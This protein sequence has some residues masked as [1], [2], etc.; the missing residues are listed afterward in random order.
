MVV[1]QFYQRG[2]CKHGDRC[3]N[4]HPGSIRDR[5]RNFPGGNT[6]SNR[7]APLSGQG[8]DRYRSGGS[9]GFGGGRDSDRRNDDFG[10][11]LSVDTIKT[12]LTGDRPIYPL[13]AYGPGRDAPRQLIEGLVEI[14]PEELRLRYYVAKASGNEVAAQQEER[15]LAA[16]MNQQVDRILKDIAGAMR[17]VEEGIKV[18]GNRIEIASQYKTSGKF[19]KGRVGLNAPTGP[20]SSN[21][22]GGSSQTPA[23]GKPATSAFGQ[24]G[25]SPFG[26]PS[27]PGQTTSAFGQP[28]N[29]GHTTSAFSQ[30]S[31]VG[32]AGGF[33]KPSLPGSTSAFGQPSGLGQ[34]SAFG[35]P[36]GRGQGSAFGKPAM[37][38]AASAFGQTNAL[39]QGSAFGKSSVPGQTSAFGQTSTPGQTSGFGQTNALGQGSAFGKPAFGQSAFGQPSQPS[40]ASPFRQQQPGSRS[41]TF[42][43]QQQSQPQS[44]PFGGNQQTPAFG[45]TG[46]GKPS[47]SPFGQQAQQAQAQNSS[48]FGQPSPATASPFGQQQQQT[49]SPFAQQQKPTTISFDH[50]APST[51]TVAT[52]GTSASA[53]IS[54]YTTHDPSGRLTSWKNRPVA[55]FPGDP[56]PYYA[57]TTAANLNNKDPNDWA[58]IWHPTGPPKQTDPAKEA[59]KE[60]KPEDYEGEKGRMLEEIYRRV[61]ELGRFGEGELVPEAPPKMAWVG[62]AV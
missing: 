48:L 57:L 19:E 2:H 36:S 31:A 28:S 53:D 54:S 7:F 40:G 25:A 49:S 39:G 26:Q 15:D 41:P 29:P 50:S 43:Q 44:S 9:G 3:F 11:H 59:F 17:Y 30:T 45:Q 51:T 12:D 1:C 27:N 56:N 21:P 52:N 46:F 61:N 4:E 60:G 34:A 32:G 58:R 10:Y 23:F 55:Y 18:P 42:A 8:G 5:N 22:F 13:S 14:S 16:Q 33:G 62:W 35:Q 20:S 6:N 47:P 24:T 38:G 37:P